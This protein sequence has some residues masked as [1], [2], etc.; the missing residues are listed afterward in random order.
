M[1]LGSMAVSA[2]QPRGTT[3][4]SRAFCRHYRHLANPYHCLYGV[5]LLEFSWILFRLECILLLVCLCFFRLTEGLAV[6]QWAL[7]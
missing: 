3:D 5:T 7:V 4:R 2:G 6:V 1:T